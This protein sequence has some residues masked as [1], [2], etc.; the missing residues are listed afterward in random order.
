[1]NAFG[2]GLAGALGGLAGGSVLDVSASPGP[3][4]MAMGL[5]GVGL[6]LGSAA[7]LVVAALR[8]R[9]GR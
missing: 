4:A 9:A 6:L 8:R 7:V 3:V 2:G 1:M 5:L